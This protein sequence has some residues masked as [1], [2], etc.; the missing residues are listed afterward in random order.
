MVRGA[1]SSER[2]STIVQKHRIAG[3]ELS[4]SKSC[5]RNSFTSDNCWHGSELQSSSCEHDPDSGC[6]DE[7]G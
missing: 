4:T 5:A 2:P 7:S 6:L 1:R 3:T